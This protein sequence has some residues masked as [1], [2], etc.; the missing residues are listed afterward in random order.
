MYEPSM[1]VVMVKENV[2]TGAHR[3]NLVNCTISCGDFPVRSMDTGEA[4]K[5]IRTRLEK[6]RSLA[7]LRD[8]VKIKRFKSDTRTKE[9]LEKGLIY[10]ATDQLIS[11]GLVSNLLNILE[12]VK[13]HYDR[14]DSNWWIIL[15]IDASLLVSNAS[16]CTRE[17]YE[18]CWVQIGLNGA[19]NWRS[20][21]HPLGR[22]FTLTSRSWEY[23]QL[24]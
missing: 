3:E 22:S 5:I 2:K 20:P 12:S 7:N 14:S 10:R 16:L 6:W 9:S 8:I 11:H 13:K 21:F 15:F 24:H 17:E 18:L 19:T 4:P 1:R 23:Y